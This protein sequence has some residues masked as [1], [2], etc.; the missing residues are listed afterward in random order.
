MAE[1]EPFPVSNLFD[2]PDLPSHTDT[3][4]LPYWA[5]CRTQYA[6]NLLDSSDEPIEY[7]HDDEDYRD[8]CFFFPEDCSWTPPN[9]W[10]VE[11][12]FQPFK[13]I[14][15]TPVLAH[16]PSTPDATGNMIPGLPDIKML[17]SEALGE[18]L[19]D[20]LSPPEITTIL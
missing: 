11:T 18:L 16:T 5:R 9:D 10:A 4:F 6:E 13:A 17:D 7:D 19:E 14:L 2:K 3:P 8:N 20:N 1:F 15:D 12:H